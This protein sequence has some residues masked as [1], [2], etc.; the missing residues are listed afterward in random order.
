MHQL[1]EALG[2]VSAACRQRGNSTNIN[3]VFRPKAEGPKDLPP[4][5]NSHP[6][7]TPKEVVDK[8]INLS[9]QHTSYGCIRLESLIK[10]QSHS[11]SAIT[12]Q[13]ILDRND[14]GTRY[15]RWLKLEEKNS[16]N[17]FKLTGE[18]VAFMEKQN[19]CFRERHVESHKPGELLNQ[20]TFYVGHLKGVG[21]VY[22]HAV[23]SYDFGFL[24]TS[25]QPEAAVAVVHNDVIPFY[26]KWNLTIENI[27]TDNG[28]EFCGT[29]S[30]A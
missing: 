14:M 24:H 10:A 25:K 26:K 11:V 19:P 12:I 13:K 16:K 4:I 6:H 21:K 5:A 3:A 7:T 1:A 20:D 28:R 27:L 17:T 18:Q 8:I 15:D 23:V 22:L 30:H 2:N 9:L 29:D